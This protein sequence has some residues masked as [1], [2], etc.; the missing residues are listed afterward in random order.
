MTF[1]FLLVPILALV[2]LIVNSMLAPHNGYDEKSDK[3]ECG[4]GSIPYQN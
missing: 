1:F 4:F 2:F 3:Y